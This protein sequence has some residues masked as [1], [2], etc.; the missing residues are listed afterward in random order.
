MTVRGPSLAAC[1]T[2]VA[3]TAFARDPFSV[4]IAPFAGYRFG[5]AVTDAYTGAGSSLDGAGA[6]G[7]T[8]DIP[9]QRGATLELLFSRQNTGVELER[10]PEVR[11]SDVT[12]DHWLAGV[13]AAI[14][15]RN[16]NVHPFVA[17][18]AGV[19][20]FSGDSGEVT[21][22]TRFAAALGGG[23]LLDVTR[24]LAV[25]LD[26]RAYASFVE[27]GTGLFCGGGGCT[28][29]FGGSALLQGEV[30]AAVVLKL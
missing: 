11:R 22:D 19:T 6:F 20:H 2:V 12:V 25:R 17:A 16:P 21:A 9:V 18:Y 8:V 15:T 27:S 30:A 1:L 13:R 5:G 4:E 7:V 28:G 24:R 23:V 3:A 14:P 26:A 29:V 10:Y